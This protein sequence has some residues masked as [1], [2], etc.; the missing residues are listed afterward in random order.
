V[1]KLAIA[2]WIHGYD[3][4]NLKFDIIAGLS[5]WALVV[6]QS[7]AY[8]HI[9]GLPPQ[10]G[11]FC[12]FA[13]PLGYA[14][15]GTSRQLIVSPTSATAAISASLVA[16]LALGSVSRYADLSMT[17]A[18]LSGLLFILLGYWKL[19]FVSQFIATSVQVGFL[20]GLGMTII[21]GQVFDLL[22][23]DSVSGPFYKQFWG[24]ITHLDETNGWTAVIGIGGLIAIFALK[25]FAPGMPAALLLV[26]VAIVV[27]SVFSLED[28]GVA[29]VGQIDRAIPLPG[30][31]TDIKFSDLATLLPGTLA[32]VIIGYSESISIAEGFADEHKY[33]VK[34]NRELTALGISAVLSG[35]F[36]GFIAGGGASQSAANDR[37]GARTQ[38]AGVVLAL[39]A[40]LTSIALMPIFKNLPS[41]ILA[42]IVIGAVVGFLNVRAMKRLRALRK[43]SFVFAL[44]ALGGVLILGILPGLLIT[45][46]LSVLLL[47]GWESRPQTSVLGRIP[48][49]TAF[50][51][52]TEVP[53]VELEPDWM[54]FRLDAP[55]LFINAS[56]MRDA[57]REELAKRSSPPEVVLLDLSLS[58]DLDVK[59][60]D[61]LAKVDEYV[62]EQGG[63][64]WLA[65]AHHRVRDMLDRGEAIGTIKKI[66]RYLT[67]DDAANAYRARRSAASATRGSDA[68]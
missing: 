5:V 40:A 1:P 12:S 24:L 68:S 15:F 48:G 6:P 55:L 32:I 10:A 47:L 13:A 42:A 64:L 20:F 61:I 11:V 67:I 50:A 14:L 2:S 43:G 31:P 62:R 39:L 3:K 19:G 33:D 41:S 66:P 36:K 58:F 17:L 65:R 7:I 9:A 29:I 49:T 54:I 28:H 26:G 45:A 44:M 30:I 16:P 38:F 59:G 22:G 18:I 8:A 37:A 25:R 46:G 57:L 23:I 21:C 53:T 35:L 63:E 4:S 60:L 52:T 34:P 27:V 51:S 56:W